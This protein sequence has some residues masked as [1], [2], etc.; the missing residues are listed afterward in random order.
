MQEAQQQ[1][2]DFE[3]Q[4][5]HMP[6]SQQDMIMRQIG[7]QMEMMKKMADRGGMELETEIR[8]IVASHCERAGSSELK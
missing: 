7:P 2:A 4:L 5:A 3:K 1:M 8:E 6:A